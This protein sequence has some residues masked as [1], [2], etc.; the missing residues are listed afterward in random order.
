MTISYDSNIGH[1]DS[2]LPVPPIPS[3]AKDWVYFSD[4]SIQLW[5]NKCGASTTP[6][7]GHHQCCHTGEAQ[8]ASRILPESRHCIWLCAEGMYYMVCA[9]SSDSR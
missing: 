2:S 8:T 5:S 7:R 1:I 6:G 9:Y 4:H 3:S